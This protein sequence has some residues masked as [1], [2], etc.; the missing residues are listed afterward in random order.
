MSF[1]TA[2]TYAIYLITLLFVV[3]F[4]PVTQDMFTTPKWLLL[5]FLSLTL[6]LSSVG[7][8][9]FSKK[10][11][12]QKKEFD[13]PLTLFVVAAA[14][15]VLFGST[16]KVQALLNPHFGLL[17]FVFLFV[18]YFFISR[19]QK[20]LPYGGMILSVFSVLFSITVL[21][22]TLP[23]ITSHLPFGLSKYQNT[24]LSGTLIDGLVFLGLAATISLSKLLKKS[25]NQIETILSFFSFVF[26]TLTAIVVLFTL[27]KNNS[28]LAL[29]S[30]AHSWY[31]AVEVLKQPMTALFGAGIDN[32]QTVFVKMKDMAYNSS[33][34][35]Q[36]PSFSLSR[37]AFFHT[38]TETGVFGLGSLLLIFSLLLKK[39]FDSEGN[40]MSKLVG[41][42]FAVVFAL[43]PPSLLLFFL[44]FVWIGIEE[45][46]EKGRVLEVDFSEI[47]PAYAL[48]VL[49]GMIAVGGA[50]YMLGRVGMSEYIFQRS[51]K[52]SNLKDVY[53]KMRGAVAYNPYNERI[54][55]NFVQVH[56][57]IANTVA[58]KATKNEKGE[59]QLSE[60][61]RQTVSQAIQAAIDEAKA[62]V[63]LNPTKASNWDLLATVYRS[64]SGVVQGADSWTISA[65][66]RA[67]VLD[68]QNPTYR[69]A[70]GGV[71]YGY[72]QYDDASRL[73]EQ[74][75][76]L[77]PEWP[78][79]QYNY[80]WSMAQKGEYQ[81]AASAM[82][83]CVSLLNP[84]R[85]AADFKKATA[86]LEEFMKKIPP[87]SQTS[88]TKP[89]GKTQQKE[90]LSLPP[91]TAPQVEPLLE[92]PKTASPE[93]R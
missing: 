14:L 59:P 40:G 63:S 86:D 46:T 47:V 24:T 20:K 88:E 35:W 61:D 7:E 81:K 45:S 5:G 89:T 52:T 2:R 48:L 49:I 4:L 41:L 87:E 9:L 34:L 74:A 3:F 15:S 18:L 13:T 62:V 72:K 50:A 8:F 53:E 29:P 77:K 1:Q 68:P 75:V 25:H 23:F 39:A 10:F 36:V 58:G 90:S 19:S 22:A 44:F 32:F 28:T 65:Y 91:T 76:S 27:V 56:L 67:I 30:F 16:N 12:W 69:V 93:A 33:P 79:A 92:L 82:K 26:T 66:Q 64:I 83:T 38:M 60:T 80:A 6:L 54:R 57:L 55:T 42:Y 84:T 37:T 31:V 11:V 17:T 73:F 85:D 51:L 43:F 70:L 71:L 78:N 21:A